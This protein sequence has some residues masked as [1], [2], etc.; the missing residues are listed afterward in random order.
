MQWGVWS[1]IFRPH[2]GGNDDTRIWMFAEPYAS[3][4]RDCTRLRG[5]LTPYVYMLAARSSSE[6]WPFSRPMW[7]DYGYDDATQ[8]PVQK[9]W[10][11]SNQYM[12]GDVL[13]NPV[14]VWA[15]PTTSPNRMN[16]SAVASVEVSTWLPAGKWSSWDGQRR[17]SPTTASMVTTEA[18]LEDTP[19]FVKEGAVL[20][21]W[22]PG[23]RKA[24]PGNRTRVFAVW[25]APK[26]QVGGGNGSWY[27]DDGESLDYAKN[28]LDAAAPGCASSGLTWTQ[29]P[30]G[31]LTMKITAPTKP[32][33]W[34]PD[35]RIYAI[36]LRGVQAGSVAAA[37]ACV[38]GTAL[39]CAELSHRAAAGDWASA[40]WWSQTAAA[41]ESAVP[42]NTVV[43]VPPAVGTN[44]VLS[45]TLQL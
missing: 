36:Q 43:V 24:H 18:K 23:R 6:S 11:V 5:A 16:A 35:E 33:S 1:A 20:A 32:V 34:S 17:W 10:Q 21:M 28:G 41:A 7:W 12:F 29:T 44:T 39:A 26:G 45:L 13:V 42:A 38:L 30:S 40:G 3:I 15:Q 25:A 2:D 4:L 27:E 9:A 14:T 22:P 19:I 8:E 31:L 37:K